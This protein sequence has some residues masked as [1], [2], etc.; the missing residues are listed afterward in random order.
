MT[1]LVFDVDGTGELNLSRV[2]APPQLYISAEDSL[3]LEIITNEP[4][5]ALQF[6]TGGVVTMVIDSNLGGKI[7]SPD[8]K[9]DIRTPGVQSEK[10]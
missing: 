6:M 3:T 5:E 1:E 2:T 4:A 8:S 7:V 10:R 9:L